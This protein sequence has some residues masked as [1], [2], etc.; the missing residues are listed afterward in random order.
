M[1]QGFRGIITVT[2][3][4]KVLSFKSLMHLLAKAILVG[5]LDFRAVMGGQGTSAFSYVPGY[6]GPANANCQIRG[7]N[8]HQASTCYY[9]QNLNYRP[10]PQFGRPPF[11]PMCFL[12]APPTGPSSGNSAQA[13]YAVS[14]PIGYYGTGPTIEHSPYAFHLTNFGQG[15][16]H[17]LL[18]LIWHLPQAMVHQLLLGILTQVLS[19]MLLMMLL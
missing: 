16:G 11:G 12:G 15:S 9:R 18:A 13:F 7:R 10:F 6:R 3:G 5:I 4:L 17:N 14:G 2:T 1:V 8:N 19:P